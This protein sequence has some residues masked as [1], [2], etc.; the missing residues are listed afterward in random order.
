MLLFL[1]VSSLLQAKF[2]Y[3]DE[4]INLDKF[5]PLVETIGQE[6]FEK[7]G[8]SLYLMNIKAVEN[9]ILIKTE[10]RVSQNLNKP[11]V[12]L[13][14]SIGETEQGK[15]DI[16]AS[17]EILYTFDKDQVL[18]PY[19]WSGT[20]IPIITS[21]IKGDVREKYG[22][23]MLNGYAD[24]AEQIADS[25]NI[26][27]ESALGNSN[28]YTINVFR[29]IFYGVLIFALSYWLYRRFIK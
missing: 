8:I 15:V 19:P 26:E 14:L 23:A 7:T 10:Q 29:A 27:L 17:P 4:I 3:K 1:L 18:S 13:S 2:I 21:K 28:K 12:L 11:F 16:Y 20:I 6:L 22:A 9:E 24:I 5:T 25:Y